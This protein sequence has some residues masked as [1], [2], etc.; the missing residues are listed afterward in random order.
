ML[1]KSCQIKDDGFNQNIENAHFDRLHVCRVVKDPHVGR[2]GHVL[3]VTRSDLRR[4]VREV[5]RRRAT[6]LRVTR[7]ASFATIWD[8]KLD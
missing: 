7:V 1:P 8:N 5:R 3:P 4:H 2:L 6:H